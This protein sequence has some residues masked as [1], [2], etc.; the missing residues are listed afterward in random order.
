MK[1]LLIAAAMMCVS[2]LAQVPVTPII[3]PHVTFVNAAGAPCWN[4]SLYSYAAGTTTPLATYVDATGTSQ[5]TNPIILDASGGANVWFGANAYK[6]VLIDSTGTTLWSVDQIS[7]L[8]ALLAAVQITPAQVTGVAVVQNPTAGQTITQPSGTTLSVNSLN[9]VLY[10]SASSELGAQI[11]AAVTTLGGSTGQGV[12][13]I[14]PS[15]SLTW[16]TAAVIQSPGISLLGYG[17]L[18]SHATCTLNGDCLKIDCSGSACHG[19]TYGAAGEYAGFSITG[20]G[21]SSQNIIHG[22]DL[23]GYNI[24]DIDLDGASAATTNCLLLEDH[25]YYTERNRINHVNFRY[26]CANALALFANGNTDPYCLTAT[27]SNLCSFGYNDIQ[28]ATNPG[29]GQRGVSM[30]GNGLLYNGSLTATF[31]MAGTS[32]NPGVAIYANNYFQSTREIMDLRGEENGTGDIGWTLASAFNSFSVGGHQ[33]FDAFANQLTGQLLTNDG[34][35]GGDYTQT[36]YTPQSGIPYDFHAGGSYL[37]PS[38]SNNGFFN[39]IGLFGRFQ[40]SSGNYMCIGDGV[41]NGCSF[42]LTNNVTGGTVFYNVPSTGGGD[43]SIP[44]SSLSTYAV[45][46]SS[47]GGMVNAAGNVTA[48]NIFASTATTGATGLATGITSVVCA[49]GYVCTSRRGALAI[50]GSSYGGSG[51]AAFTWN[52]VVTPAVQGCNVTQMG[53]ATQYGVGML[54]GAATTTGVPVTVSAAFTGTIY[55]QYNCGPN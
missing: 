55:A 49:G 35:W 27:P 12:I 15:T 20:N 26:G 42:I 18:A 33:Y 14:P 30:T 45:F 31:N 34:G 25:S 2:A 50:V 32:V 52:W 23:V 21:G 7:S 53:G 47:P 43:Q 3:N 40:Y 17:P 37:I 13:V 11:N 46:S 51:S 48:Q 6:L 38:Y 44:T 39:G 10:L 29:P 41:H 36:T 19:A 8:G 1:K 24:H 28:I 54:S 9:N 4:C 22:L 5:N 16:A